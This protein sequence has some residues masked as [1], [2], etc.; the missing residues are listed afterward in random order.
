[1][2]DTKNYNGR[3]NIGIRAQRNKNDE[4]YTPY[5]TVEILFE[6]YMAGVDFK[7]KTIY[8]FCDSDES[9]FVK[10]LKDNKLR[11]GYKELWHT[12]DD[13]N[14]HEDLFEKADYVITNPPFSKMTKDLKPLLHKAKKFLVF[15]SVQNSHAYYNNYQDIEGIRIIRVDDHSTYKFDNQE[16]TVNIVFLTNIKEV[17]DN[18][19]KHVFTNTFDKL[20]KK[21]YGDVCKSK[22]NGPIKNVLTID[23][24]ADLPVDYQGYMLIPITCVFDHYEKIYDIINNHPDI[25]MDFKTDK[26]HYNIYSD[27]K[28]R[29]Q[30][31]L[32]KLKKYDK[33][34]NEIEEQK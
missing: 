21:V 31:F 23:K 27:G 22:Y 6:K 26:E 10:Y 4:F 34:E 32:V 7:D 20:E 17:N 24:M 11:L 15:G 33:A 25:R 16:H 18:K 8:C 28:S 3:I 30:R 29:Y 9:N 13:Y 5:S 14:N 2:E 12:W 1:M 19:K